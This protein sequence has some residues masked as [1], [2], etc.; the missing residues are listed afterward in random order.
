[1]IK[2]VLYLFPVL[3]LMSFISSAQE[4]P[5]LEMTGMRVEPVTQ[6]TEKLELTGM[7]TEPK[8]INVKQANKKK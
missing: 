1:M 5:A 8:T 7:A 4:M 6:T 3:Y 2:K